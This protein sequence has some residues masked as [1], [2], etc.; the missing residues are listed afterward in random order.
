MSLLKNIFAAILV[1]SVLS[2]LEAQQDKKDKH[3]EQ[4]TIVG[5]YE[6]K[7]NDAFKINTKPEIIEPEAQHTEFNFQLPNIKQN[8]SI[9]LNAIKPVDIRNRNRT[10]AYNDYLKLGFGSRISPYIDFFHSKSDKGNYNFTAN[11]YHYSSFSN[12]ENY[13]P[14]PFSKT[15]AKVN[16]QKFLD[17][18]ILDLG[19]KYGL[20]TNKYYGYI[21]DDFPGITIPDNELKQMFNLMQANVG[22][23]SNYKRKSK[24]HHEVRLSAYY[25]FDR[26]KTSEMNTKFDFD[27]HKG[28]DVVD[29]LDYQNLGLK[30]EFDFY[31][32]SDTL[33]SLSEFY[34]GVTPYFTAN[35]GAFNFNAGLK[36]GLLNDSTS[37]F[38]FWPDLEVQMN[39][40]PES[41]TIFAGIK[42]GIEKQSYYKLTTENPYLSP[43]SQLKYLNEK[44][45]VYGGFKLS[46][47]QTAG[48]QI[49]AGWRSFEDMAF[50]INYGDYLLQSQIPFGP[51]NKF[52]TAF[53]DGNE[54]YTEASISISAG[55]QFKINIG[56]EYHTYSLDSLQ[57][58]YHKPLTKA[59]IGGS[60]SFAEKVKVSLEMVFN[61][62]RYALNSNGLAP[63][64]VELDSY[65]DLNAEVE[66][67]INENLSAFLNGTNLL[68]NYYQQFYSYPVQGLQ[69]MAGISYRF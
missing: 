56:G 32:N 14:S 43:L 44:I 3:N 61:G 68:N 21:P 50:F 67:R 16:Y 25:Y 37:S 40:V 27:I 41:F 28:F 24:L 45:N 33:T 47:A 55:K 42:G 19:F 7:I 29:M 46:I 63:K 51:L 6:P 4:V 58:A 39:V 20:N 11:F 2:N 69:I 30:G 10:V 5:S 8:T 53:D 35:Y 23:S 26:F 48:F 59:F 36:L 12:I 13:S 18:H 38:H 52:Y 34:V 31:S 65:V 17:N 54:F 66:Y 60:Y 1:L 15:H 62:K 22:F 9:E 57:Q 49:K 64:E